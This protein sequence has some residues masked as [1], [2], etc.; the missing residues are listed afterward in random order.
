MKKVFDG[1]T[2][3]NK[4]NKAYQRGFKI[5]PIKRSDE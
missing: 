1:S 2:K 3:A 5:G 4:T